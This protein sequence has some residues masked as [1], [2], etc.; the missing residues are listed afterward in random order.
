M[1]HEQ[2]LFTDFFEGCLRQQSI[3]VF[4]VWLFGSEILRTL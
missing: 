4:D 2:P 3:G 1:F